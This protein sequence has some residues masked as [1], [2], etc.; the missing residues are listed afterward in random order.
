MKEIDARKQDCPTPVIMT[1][2][3]IETEQP[4]LIRII[5]D[6]EAAKENVSRFLDSKKYVVSVEQSEGNFYVS[7]QRGEGENPDVFMEKKEEEADQQK[8]VVMITTDRMGNGDDEL[9]LKLMINFVKTLKEMGSELWRLIFV[10]AGVKLTIADTETLKSLQELEKS[11]I[12]IMVCGTCLDH[13]Q[14]LEKKEVGQTTNMLDI[15]MALQFSDKVI[16]L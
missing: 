2:E 14:L 13:F 8:I 11:G 4:V 15:I 6:N 3:A 10:N 9:G 7:G 5:V 12:N 1:K 16:N